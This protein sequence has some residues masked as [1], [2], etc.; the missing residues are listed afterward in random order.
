MP[1]FIQTVY[2]SA[3]FV[4]TFGLLLLSKGLTNHTLIDTDP[5]L[6][7]SFGLG[8]IIMWGVCYFACAHAAENWSRI[9]LAFALEKSIYFVAWL[10]FIQSPIDWDLLYQQDLFAGIFYSLYGVVDGLFMCLFITCAYRADQNS[11]VSCMN[12]LEK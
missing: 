3:A 5:T 6:F 12:T 9:S 11:I 2:F 7:S 1:R 8:M 4:N 10:C